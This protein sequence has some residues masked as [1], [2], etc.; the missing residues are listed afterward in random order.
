MGKHSKLKMPE[1]CGE[2]KKFKFF[3]TYYVLHITYYILHITDYILRITYYILRITYYILRITY[4]NVKKLLFF[5]EK[6]PKNLKTPI[7]NKKIYSSQKYLIPA[8]FFFNSSPLFLK[9]SQKMLKNCFFLRKKT[10]IFNKK[11]IKSSPKYLIP[12]HFFF[13]SSPHFFNSRRKNFK[14][15]FF[16]KKK[17]KKKTL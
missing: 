17:K 3:F 13:N 4:Y 10:L 11:Q 9:S 12:A 6:K 16:F 5:K 15:F 1:N 7:F 2:S 14:K 8:H